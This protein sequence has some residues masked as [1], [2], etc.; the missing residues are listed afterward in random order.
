MIAEN[1]PRSENDYALQGF[2][3]LFPSCEAPCNPFP[4][5]DLRHF[6]Q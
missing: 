1:N 2:S 3:E 4:D 5:A 6:S